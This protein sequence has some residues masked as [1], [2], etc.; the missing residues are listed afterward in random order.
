MPPSDP[1]G[2]TAHEERRSWVERK[3]LRQKRSKSRLKRFGRGLA[4][5]AGQAVGTAVRLPM[6]TLGIGGR[7]QRRPPGQ[8]PGTLPTFTEEEREPARLRSFRYDLGTYVERETLTIEE[9]SEK[10]AKP[11]VLWVDVV[12]ARDPDAIRALGDAF[13]LHPLVQEDLINTTQRPKLEAYSDSARCEDHLFIVVKML[14]A[15]GAE[16]TAAVDSSEV[17][18]EQVGLV[19]GHGY[20]LSFQEHEGDVFEPVRERVRQGSRIREF[21]PDYLAYALLDVIVDHY[22]SVVEELGDRI[23]SIEE[24]VLEDP[25]PEVQHEINGLRREVIFLRRQ[26]WPL[27]EVLSALMREESPLIEERTKVYLRDVYDHT[28][29][30][31]DAIESFRD[32][33][34]S[35]VDLYLSALSHRM[36]EVMKV[37]T[38]IGSIFIPLSFLTGLYGMN[39]EY[40]PELQAHY[41]YF[42]FLGV[43]GALFVGMLGYFRYRGW[44]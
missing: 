17:V 27:R 16:G 33:V 36:N 32:V 21:G 29:Q 2:P 8:A 14:H 6:Q 11:G 1:S 31:V 9:A 25:Q 15:P 28:I 22:F 18:V 39:F 26:I 34:S 10:R 13:G 4:K 41:G 23:E 35:L 30:V 19:I 43:I 42:V 5:G 20:V 44:L 7:Q 37:L 24:E 12:G 40:I 38:V 3:V